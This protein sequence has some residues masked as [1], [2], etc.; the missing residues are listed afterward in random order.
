VWIFIGGILSAVAK[1]PVAA[2]FPQFVGGKWGNSN[3]LT[4]MAQIH[5]AYSIIAAF[6]RFAHGK[7]K[8]KILAFYATGRAPNHGAEGD[9]DLNA[10]APNFTHQFEYFW[11]R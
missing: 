2:K 8:L 11:P 10:A 3:P 9:L 5:D 4:C 7:M 1:H 6:V